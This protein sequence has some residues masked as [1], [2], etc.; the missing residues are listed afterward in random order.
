[1]KRALHSPLAHRFPDF[2]FP[3]NSN[4]F[5]CEMA[6]A[7]KH[8]S[9]EARAFRWGEKGRATGALFLGV[10]RRVEVLGKNPSNGLAM[11]TDHFCNVVVGVAKFV[12]NYNASSFFG[13]EH[14]RNEIGDRNGEFQVFI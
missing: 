2:F 4:S 1:M 5:G 3:G 9:F 14:L 6:P 11:T 7:I 12:C 8:K 10:V 13:R